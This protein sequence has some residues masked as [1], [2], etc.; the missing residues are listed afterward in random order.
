[1]HSQFESIKALKAHQNSQ[2]SAVLEKPVVENHIEK[3]LLDIR[4]AAEYLGMSEN[5]L[6]KKVWKRQVPFAVKIGR[7]L[8]FDKVR[9]DE[10]IEDN[11]LKVEKPAN[12]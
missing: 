3:R 5:A 8:R 1:M 12:P 11:C 9:M 2:I 7:T 6:Y 10:W 4:E